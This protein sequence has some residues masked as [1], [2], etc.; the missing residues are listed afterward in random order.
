MQSSY[1]NIYL[2]A[3]NCYFNLSPNFLSPCFISPE[4]KAQAQMRYDNEY[5]DGL[6]SLSVHRSIYLKLLSNFM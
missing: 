5:I 1:S 6:L 4:S 2:L 3:S